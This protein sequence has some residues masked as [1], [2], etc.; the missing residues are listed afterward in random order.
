M[1]L[2]TQVWEFQEGVRMPMQKKYSRT[3]NVVTFQPGKIVTLCILKEDRVSTDN[4]RLKCMVKNISHNRRHL[5][6]T[7]FGIL[8]RLHLT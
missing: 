2:T 1:A 5:L 8:D 7:Q 3:H 6:Q 4:H